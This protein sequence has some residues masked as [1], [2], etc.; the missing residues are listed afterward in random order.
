[1]P[2]RLVIL[3]IMAIVPPTCTEITEIWHTKG[4]YN[5]DD[6]LKAHLLSKWFNFLQ[7]LIQYFHWIWNIKA[8]IMC[9]K[10]E[11][12]KLFI[13]TSFKQIHWSAF[14]KCTLRVSS[15]IMLEQ[16]NSPNLYFKLIDFINTFIFVDL[17]DIN[18]LAIV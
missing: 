3:C 1:M 12:N 14:W 7:V 6:T 8:P 10:N 15:D 16:W 5:T 13:N 9:L 18:S 4:C 17:T 11:S 2:T